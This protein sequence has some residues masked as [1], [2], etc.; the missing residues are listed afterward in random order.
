[1][2]KKWM[3]KW[4]AI[5]LS[6]MFIAGS[7]TALPLSPIQTASAAA[8]VSGSKLIA[9]GKKYLGV[10]YK[11]GGKTPKAFDCQGFTRYV[12]SK[13]GVNLP[14]GARN[15][16][17]VGKYVS[18]SNLK[19][20]DLVFFST[21]ATK[22]YSSSSIKRIGHVGIYAGNGKVLHTYGKGGVK[23]SDLNSKWWKSHYVTARRV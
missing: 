1:M 3:K 18:R 2:K 11:L 21:S 17:K 15:Q 4:V 8:Q 19:V 10:P 22:K 13:Q 12:F 9:T 16:S 7:F 6:A 23:F 5:G 20:G 14:S